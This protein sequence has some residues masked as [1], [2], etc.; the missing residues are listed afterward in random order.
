MPNIILEGFCK[1]LVIFM[2]MQPNKNIKNFLNYFLGPLLFIWLVFS[3]YRQINSQQHL[4][5][6][7][8]NIKASLQSAKVI[9]LIIVI[10]LVPVNWG[11]EAVKWKLSINPIYPIRFW[12]AFKA[13]LSGVSFSV[14]MPNRVGEYLG[15]M[16][17]LPDGNRLKTISITLMGSIS[18]L[19]ITLIAGTVG[20]IYL[21]DYLLHSGTINSLW[22]RFILV[23]LIIVMLI[24]TLFYFQIS[25]LERLMERW[26]KNNRYLYLV[27]SLHWFDGQLLGR[28]LLL[29]LARYS[30][31]VIQYVLL[32]NL[33]E[34]Y[35]PLDLQINTMGVIFL[36]LA[37]IPS[38]ALVEVVLRGEVSLTLMGLFTTNSLGIG[39]TSVSIWLINLVL[40]AIIGSL[41]I[42]N[43]KVF[44]RNETT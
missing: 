16:L 8:S 24:L 10:L 12:E 11:I 17:Y 13:V 5:A 27:Q 29:S 26:L 35:V 30:I 38:I 6:W 31:F 14:T 37:I 18:Q 21:K 9:Y 1:E 20:F 33:F 3:I 34:V 43:V 22:Y 4:E 32:F 28:L 40:P 41:L 39:L 36:A 42:L 19:L 44:K 7:W 2:P 15:R 23:G 25:A